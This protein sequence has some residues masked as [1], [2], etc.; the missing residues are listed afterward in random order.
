MASASGALPRS[1]R[2]SPHS[3]K[4]AALFSSARSFLVSI[5]LSASSNRT[6]AL[7]G[8]AFVRAFLALLRASGSSPSLMSATSDALSVAVPPP[9]PSV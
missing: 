5:S 2:K 1:A 9:F 4:S 6:A 8:W 7:S 3:R